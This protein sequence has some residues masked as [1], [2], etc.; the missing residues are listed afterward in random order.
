MNTK[1]KQLPDYEL[2]DDVALTD[3]GDEMVLLNLESGAYFGLNAVGSDFI[4]KIKIEEST[5]QA[6]N[7]IANDYQVDLE[8]VI[9]DFEELTTELLH[10]NLITEKSSNTKL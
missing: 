3:M 4:N 8:E 6:L 2:A 5:H 1:L 10:H 9:A 7:D